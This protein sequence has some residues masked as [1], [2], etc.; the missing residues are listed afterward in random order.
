MV[1]RGQK[2]VDCSGH[3]RY[4]GPV[5]RVVVNAARVYP[6]SVYLEVVKYLPEDASH[7][8]GD[9]FADVTS[10]VSIV[11]PTSIHLQQE[12]ESEAS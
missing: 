5:I 4:E 6:K 9:V 2:Y 7:I 12:L 1:R 8:E 10:L 11:D 3:K